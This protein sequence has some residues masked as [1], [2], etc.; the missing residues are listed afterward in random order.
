MTPTPEGGIGDW[1]I[2]KSFRTTEIGTVKT[3]PLSL[4]VPGFVGTEN[5]PD[6]VV[7]EEQRD[8]VRTGEVT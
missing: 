5:G 7:E 4:V 8:G 2:R 3:G 6:K 1:E